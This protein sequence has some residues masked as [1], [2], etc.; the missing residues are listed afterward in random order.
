MRTLILASVV[1][2][3]SPV[4]AGNITDF[5][6]QVRVDSTGKGMV[7]FKSNLL[8]SP[9]CAQEPSG[10]IP[11]GL[12]FDTNTAGGR[13]IQSLA[14]AALL[15]GKKLSAVGTGMCALYGNAWVEDWSYGSVVN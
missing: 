2:V 7:I 4:L 6:A 9:S 13:A 10:G 3:S 14:T 8:T 11:S 5:V 12:A 15:A 1:C